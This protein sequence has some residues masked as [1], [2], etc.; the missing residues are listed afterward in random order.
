MNELPPGAVRS[1]STISGAAQSVKNLIRASL[2][3]GSLFVW[4]VLI[5]KSY[6]PARDSP[7]ETSL[8]VGFQFTD[9]VTQMLVNRGIN[10]VQYG[11]PGP[12]EDA[13]LGE[14]ALFYWKRGRG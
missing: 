8:F 4:L 2:G 7:A 13:T 5:A 10:R 6:M 12:E 11:S 1:D 9:P 3:M 14:Y